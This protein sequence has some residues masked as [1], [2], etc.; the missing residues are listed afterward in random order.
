MILK[1]TSLATGAV[2]AFYTRAVVGVTVIVTC[3]SILTRMTV[4]FI[5]FC[6]QAAMQREKR[7]THEY[8]I[9]LI[10]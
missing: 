1:H 6:K 7:K 8:S 4:T 9:T 2:V 5:N 3:S 10:N